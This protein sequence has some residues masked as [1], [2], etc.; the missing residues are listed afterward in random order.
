[1]A[2]SQSPDRTR[3]RLLAAL[4]TSSLLGACIVVPVG[5]RHGGRVGETDDGDIVTVAPPPLQT[6]AVIIAPGPGYFWIS[7]YWGWI[8]GRHVWVGGRWEG[9]RPGW[10]WV[11][12]GWTRYRNGWRA[13]PGRWDRR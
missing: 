2:Q 3:L 6:E 1:M 4:A 12:Y 10:Q 7:G 9:H 13:S 11:P 5:H 8:G